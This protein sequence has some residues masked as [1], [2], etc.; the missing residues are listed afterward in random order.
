MEINE[1]TMVKKGGLAMLKGSDGKIEVL[2]EKVAYLAVI[3]MAK[4]Y[5]G[6]K[7]KIFE[8]RGQ[9]ILKELLVKMDSNVKPW[10]VKTREEFE[11]E[12]DI[13]KPVTVG[14]KGN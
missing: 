9:Q 8:S 3:E 4:V 6:S 13:C 5:N 14:G 10:I 11:Y 2:R 1:K 12:E 7:S